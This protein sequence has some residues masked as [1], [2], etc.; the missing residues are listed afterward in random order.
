MN[1]FLKYIKVDPFI[2]SKVNLTSVLEEEGITVVFVGLSL[3]G[4]GTHRG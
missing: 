2:G 1:R 4:G 3:R